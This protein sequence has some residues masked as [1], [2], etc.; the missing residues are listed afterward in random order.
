MC[1]LIGER[2]EDEIPI[3]AY[4]VGDNLIDNVEIAVFND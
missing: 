3:M 1:I 4:G 2:Y